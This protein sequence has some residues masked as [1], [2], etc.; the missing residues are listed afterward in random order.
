MHPS[1]ERPATTIEL[2]PL[3]LPPESDPQKTA[4]STG[5]M[6]TDQGAYESPTSDP[7]VVSIV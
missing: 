4:L 3:L 5:S 7:D 1:A 2:P 6:P